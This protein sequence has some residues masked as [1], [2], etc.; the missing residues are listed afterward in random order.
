MPTLYLARYILPISAP[1]I[2]DG[3]LLV[4][5]DRIAA[6]GTRRQLCAKVPSKDRVDF[7]DAVLLP[8]LVNAHTHL[9]L[10][11]FPDWL[12]Q[13]GE[14]PTEGAFVDWILQVIRIKR[15]RP[16]E[17]YQPSLEAGIRLSLEAGTGA[18]GDILSCFPARAGYRGA[19]LRG[20]LFLETLGRDPSQG[21]KVLQRIGQILGEKTAGKLHLG[22]SPH[23]PY[24]LSSEYMEAVLDS[25]R[26]HRVKTMTHLAESLEETQFFAE[27]SGDLA[28]RLYTAVGWENMLPPPARRSP[29]AYL[30]DRGGLVPSNI[31]VHGVQ[32][33]E[34]DV[35]RLARRGCIVVLCP[36]SNAA[37]DVGRA[38]VELYRRAGVPLALGT[39]SLASCDNL[40]VWDEIGFARRAFGS[41]LPPRE[42][43]Q[44]ATQNGAN[45]LGVDGEVGSLQEGRGASFQVLVPDELPPLDQLEEFLC[46]GPVAD[47]VSVLYLEGEEVLQRLQSGAIMPGS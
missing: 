30:D 22:M 29:V 38:P 46:S 15:S 16:L 44:M 3:A 10:T 47:K 8:P 32:V 34:E 6:L 17:S 11:H 24:S 14:A 20:Q 12:H 33:T 35:D 31:L 39:D 23:S 2:E 36:R 9:E 28:T 19:P 7:G 13:A 26:R 1:P 45:A 43:L 37:L 25:A 18:V 5:G 4:D 40:S 21:R 41:S 27:S 42:L